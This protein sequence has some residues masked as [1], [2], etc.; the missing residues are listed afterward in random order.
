VIA[1]DHVPTGAPVGESLA[2][3][4][5]EVVAAVGTLSDAVTAAIYQQPQVCLVDLNRPYPAQARVP[6]RQSAL[7]LLDEL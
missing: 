1:Y 7:R 6:D 2:A 3:Q 5:F 4:G